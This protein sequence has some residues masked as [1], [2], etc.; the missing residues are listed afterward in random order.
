MP[1]IYTSNIECVNKKYPSPQKNSRI[2]LGFCFYSEGYKKYVSNW[3]GVNVRLTLVSL[4]H[5]CFIFSNLIEILN[6]K[7]CAHCVDAETTLVLLIISS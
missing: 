1:L 4:S 3:N 2:W 5:Y 7:L 6:I